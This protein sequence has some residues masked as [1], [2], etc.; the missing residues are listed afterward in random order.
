MTR[1]TESGESRIGSKLLRWL[2]L[3]VAFGMGAFLR[4]YNLRTA[5]GWY[6]DEG[7]WVAIASDLARGDTGYL[8][9]GESFF[10]TGHPPLFFLLLAALFRLGGT[11]ILWARLLSAGSGF[12]ALLL[13]YP[14]TKAIAG[15]RI[16]V[17]ATLLYALYPA[18]V[19]YTRI[20]FTYSLLTPL[21][22]L[23]LY[24]IQRY[25]SSGQRGWVL[26]AA[27]CAGLCAAT[28]LAGAT[29]PLFLIG[30][31]LLRQPRHALVALP[32]ITLPTVCWVAWMW[33]EAGSAFSFD[34][35][36]T[37]S[38]TSSP[39]PVQLARVVIYYYNALSWDLWFALG[40]LGLFALPTS[41]SRGLIGG[42][43]F[44]AL[45]FLMRTVN[46]G[47]LGYYFL[48]PYH[49]IICVGMASLLIKGIVLIKNRGEG[50]FHSWLA[51]RI[52]RLRW[53]RRVVLL[54]NSLLMFLFILSPF[55]VTVYEVT[56]FDSI[57][58]AR[59]SAA[60]LFAPPDTGTE[61]VSYINS[62]T[63][64]DDVVLASPTITWLI[65]AQAADFQMAVA[66]SGQ[67]SYHLPGNLPPSRFRYDPSLATATY[68]VID[69][70]W[71]GWASQTMPEVAEMVQEVE[72]GWNLEIQ[73]GDFEV[74]RN[75]GD[76]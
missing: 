30:I 13:I 18:A 16:G 6:S 19:S 50:D 59:I 51:T 7:S 20:G 41:R 22:L 63:S 47:G 38:R 42:F 10:I 40:T 48:I 17:V 72:E 54:L 31:L 71:R 60:G 23:G 5:P 52:P 62:H 29:F 14:V 44:V 69:P 34:L 27:L 26:L 46:I 75:P 12:L 24:T 11:D 55:L 28:E 43:Y 53:R 58:L 32:I 76:Q 9:I 4:F 45:V 57:P 66:A 74:Y 25:W 8:A 67:D 35:A 15:R 37:L 21:Y 64:D 36:F 56:S 33:I 65:R 68:V 2:I 73:F 1:D 70:L 3:A 61:V 39:L 49:P